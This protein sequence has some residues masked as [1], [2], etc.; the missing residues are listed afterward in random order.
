VADKAIAAKMATAPRRGLSRIEA[1]I[2]VG[3]GLTKFDELVAEG[4]MP[5]P[6]LIDGRKVWDI[7]RLD[8]AFDDL[9]VDGQEGTWAD[10]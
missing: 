8:L 7:R 9:P 10:R 5:G 4:R 2:Y 3:V 6:R 1:A